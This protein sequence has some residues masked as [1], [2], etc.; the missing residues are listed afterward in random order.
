[1]P[2]IAGD[3]LKFFNNWFI[4]GDYAVAGTGLSA[5][6]GVGTIQMSGVPCVNGIG[7]SATVV[8]GALPGPC[9]VAGAVPAYPIAA[10]L[11]WQTV[12]N[13]ASPVGAQGTFNSFAMNGTLVGSDSSSA[14]W[15]SSAPQQTLRVYRADVLRFLPL[16]AAAPHVQLANGTHRVALG[17]AAGV[18]ATEG[19]SLV[20]IYRIIAPGN[21][22]IAPLR[23]VVIYDGEYTVRNGANPMNQTILGFYQ[24]S[25]TNPAATMTHIVGNGQPN[26]RVNLTLNGGTPQTI[27][28][29]QSF[30]GAQG[31][32]WDNL[33]LNFALAPNASSA[34]TQAVKNSNSDC[35]SWGTVVTAANVQDTDH[36]GLLDIWE[37]K[38][39]HRNIQASPATFGG[40]SDYPN[41]PCVNL[42]AMGAVN[43]K[44]DI[45]IQI[46]WMHS[47]D[48]SHVP[49]QSALDA[50]AKT[51]A[52]HNIALHFD[53]GPNYQGLG[54]PYIVP[55]TPDAYGNPLAQGGSDLNESTLVCRAAKCAY[56]EQYPVLSF[57]FGLASVRDGNQSL[58]ISPHFNQNRKDVFHYALFAHA[59]AGPFDLLGRPTTPD[60][61][62]V[63]GEADRPGGDILV[64]LGLWRSDIAGNDQVGS[65]LVQAGTLMHELGHNLDL[66]HGGWNSTPNCMPN[67]P[68]VMNYLYQTRGLTDANGIE[69]IDYSSGLLP[70]LSES[71]L[72][73]QFPGALQYRLRY[74]SPLGPNDPVGRAAQLH[75]DGTPISPAEV[76]AIR[77]ETNGLSVPD[78]SNGTVRPGSPI[79]SLDVNFDGTIGQTFLDQSDWSSLNLQHIGGRPMFGMLSNGVLS[80]DAGVLSSDA[81]VLSSDAGVLS[82]DAGSMAVDPGVLSS[83]AGVLSSDAGVLSSDAGVLSSDAG[84]VDY[85]TIIRTS[86]DPPP[87][88]QQCAGC[89]VV[90]TNGISSV[91]LNWTSPG[92]GGQLAYRIYRCAGAG[93][94]VTAAGF[95]GS[96]TSLTFTDN[97][98]NPNDAGASCPAGQ[99]C[100]NTPYTYAVTS[101]TTAGAESPFSTTASSQVTHLFVI[102]DNQTV[103]YGNANPTP[104]FQVYGNVAGTLNTALVNCA[105]MPTTPR[106]AGQYSIACTGPVTTSPTD[107]VSY[108]LRYT[109][110]NPGVLT[111]QTR[112]ITV[113]ASASSK[114]YDGTTSSASAP[115]ITS[116][117]LAYSDT[118]TWIETY[119]NPTVGTTHVMTPTGTVSD[120]NGGNNYAITFVP[121]STGIILTRPVTATLAAQNKVYD[122][123]A[124]EPD[125]KMSC[126]LANT[127]AGD[128]IICTASAGTF[129][130]NQVPAATTVSA[131]ATLGGA[132]A[133][134]YTL[135]ATGSTVNS[136]GVSAPAQITPAPLTITGSSS[137]MTYGSPAPTI[138]PL[139]NGFVNGETSLALTAQPNCS[140][141]YTPA[142]AVGTYP[143]T[144]AAA[145]AI[146]YSITYA[147]GTVTVNPAPLTI[148]PDGGKVKIYGQT[149]SAFTGAAA[150]LFNGDAVSITYASAGT[151]PAAQAGAYDVTVAGYTFTHGSASN[152]AVTGGKAVGGLT[153][154]Q[155]SSAT[156]IPSTNLSGRLTM[157]VG[158]SVTDNTT[159]STGTPT[160]TVTV[161]ASTGESCSATL[162][163]G[164]GSCSLVFGSAGRNSVT[165]VYGGDSNFKASTSSAVSVNPH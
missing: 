21:P 103:V 73:G 62:S 76:P 117:T 26:S 80:S 106:N 37:T 8:P 13:T 124:T 96:T 61:K 132:K 64:T 164:A 11:Y 60:P 58:G 30:T 20:V 36:D 40:C 145:S 95:L 33:S 22:L 90:A 109:T 108:N 17:S 138:T 128:A 39:L 121:I 144:C 15:I 42:P 110:T 161:T 48:H 98:N 45:F 100:Y 34:S 70:A 107:G 155:A 12:E 125:A 120:G 65:D 123:S 55:N 162:S 97:V 83:D 112:P 28:L 38:G 111:I 25:S 51:F 59:L 32:S 99:T 137:T 75:C 134:N 140:T 131:T 157:T 49:K 136:T 118:V 81:G 113:T 14:C 146:N 114:T 57:K 54:L 47:L 148:T 23:S 150:T 6:Q 93:C 126:S 71:S 101:L 10:F 129:N 53:V 149:Y 19:A 52:A 82:S 72:S 43:G 46:D 88:A 89:G 115:T 119:D 154:T 158:V 152:Y 104:T 79:P 122:G 142:T 84:D 116:G 130:S 159:G 92:T 44:Q 3:A 105:Y 86:V 50:V 66:S 165:A 68:S 153:I 35:L 16:G 41:E 87:S 24:A 102:A 160:G 139:Y 147:P 77:Q 7:P 4:T 141:T 91:T 31:A 163:S 156:T 63:S 5:T 78:W 143:A 135:G 18:L 29:D 9:S 127:I 85:D 69:H 2:A 56:N 151:A 67:Y 1:L 133:A 94:T 74:Y 27:T